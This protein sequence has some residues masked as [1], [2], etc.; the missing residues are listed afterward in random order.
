MNDAKIVIY[1]F[2]IC[3]RYKYCLNDLYIFK[4]K[5]IIFFAIFF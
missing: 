1:N 2:Y 5:S 3:I 4:S